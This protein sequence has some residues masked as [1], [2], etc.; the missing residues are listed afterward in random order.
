MRQETP[1]TQLAATKRTQQSDL[2]YDL[3]MQYHSELYS[4]PSLVDLT[5]HFVAANIIKSSDA[6]AVA[7]TIIMESQTAALRKLLNKI[8]LTLLLGDG[9]S[10]LFDKMLKT[11]QIYSEDTVQHLATD[12]LEK[13]MKQQSAVPITSGM[14]LGKIIAKQKQPGCKKGA[15][16]IRSHNGYKRPKTLI[17]SKAKKLIILLRILLLE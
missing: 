12:M 2:E 15:R 16:P 1:Q 6:E 8:S 10:K 13:I 4:V 14:Q 17:S 11:M 5:S 9:D 3:F 7:N